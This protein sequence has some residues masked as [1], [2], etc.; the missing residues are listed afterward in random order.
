MAGTSWRILLISLSA[1]CAA[2]E[3]TA[4]PVVVSSSPDST[5]Q[6]HE[7]RARVASDKA[8]R[9]V[10][11]WTRQVADGTTT[12]F[13]RR[14]AVVVARTSDLGATWSNPVQVSGPGEL[15]TEPAVVTDRAGNWNIIWNSGDVLSEYRLAVAHSSDQGATWTLAAGTGAQAPDHFGYFFPSIVSTTGSTWVTAAGAWFTGNAAGAGMKLLTARSTSPAPVAWT[16]TGIA[17]AGEIIGSNGNIIGA[18]TACDDAGNCVLVAAGAAMTTTTGQRVLVCRS[19]DGGQTW[20]VPVT[21]GS[22]SETTGVE[23][24]PHLATDGEGTWIA[25]W[26]KLPAG[27]SAGDYY[28]A[29]SRSTDNGATWTSPQPLFVSTDPLLPVRPST[30]PRV[31]AGAHGRWIVVFEHGSVGYVSSADHGQSWSNLTVV[32]AS[33]QPSPGTGTFAFAPDVTEIAAGRWLVVWE[34]MNLDAENA[35]PSEIHA[36]VIQTAP[37]TA[38]ADWTLY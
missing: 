28:V 38:A 26:L 2:A 34:S 33:A 20:S 9:A 36:T 30:Q 6:Y 32:E 29:W 27:G 18:H 5:V 3:Q 21:L 10:V 35:R 25:A 16:H 23:T 12:P 24:S 22:A 31:A 7:S 13:S 11:A 15:A 37:S 19:A 8:G 14:S 4:A 1:A 17:T